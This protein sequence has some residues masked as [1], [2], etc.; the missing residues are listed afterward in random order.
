MVSAAVGS[1]IAATVAAAAT[2][3]ST[4]ISSRQAADAQERQLAYQK[5]IQEQQAADEA[6][7]KKL[8]NEAQERNRAYG[9]SLLDG[10]S[11]LD[12][13]LTSSWDGS[14]SDAGSTELTTTSDFNSGS[15]SS[16][17]A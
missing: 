14:D 11:Q 16:M 6:T 3:G 8:Q 12:N 17:F 2:I 5:Q 4:M 7:E 15:V 13:I 1:I 9:A 10:N